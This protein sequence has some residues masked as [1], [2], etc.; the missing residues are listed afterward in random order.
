MEAGRLKSTWKD[1]SV[2]SCAH[3][4]LKTLLSL[5]AVGN[6]VI[7]DIP[8]MN[9]NLSKNKHIILNFLGEG[10]GPDD[11]KNLIKYLNQ[12]LP[13]DNIKV[14]FNSVINSPQDYRYSSFPENM[15]NHY[16]FFDSIDA[17]DFNSYSIKLD[18][19]FLCLNRRSSN[20]RTKLIEKLKEKISIRYS[21]NSNSATLESNKVL[22]D[23][24]IDNHKQHLNS[25]N[26]FR[27]CL[28]NI[29]NE[30]S[31]QSTRLLYRSIFITEKTFKAF[32]LR[33]IPVWMAVPGLVAEV[34]KLG[35]DLFDDI[36]KNHY[37]DN[38]QDEN[39][40]CEQVEELC[41][42]L[43]RQFSIAQ[44]QELRKNIWDRLESNYNLLK[45][46]IMNNKETSNTHFKFLQS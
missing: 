44:C 43:D 26:I 46:Y 7:K 14:L 28:F 22:I 35:F 31:D 15:V 20:I 6:Q 32:A 3:Y 24:L 9:L 2:Y 1:T 45:K 19:K 13:I 12:T 11:I 8:I 42:E 40:R 23:G 36:C 4:T 27:S 25:D 37:Y 33:Q 10:H 29:I 18:R 16:G 17:V 38:T 21:L 41:G 34:K 39:V 5:E 30:S